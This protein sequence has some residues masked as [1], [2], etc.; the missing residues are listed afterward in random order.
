MR[1][2]VEIKARVS[3]MAGLKAR[4]K[5]VADQGPELIVQEDTFFHT[6]RGRLK[7][8]K[9]NDLQGELIYYERPD[10]AGPAQ[11][12]Y[13]ITP[14]SEPD[15]VIEMLSRSHGVKGVIRKKRTL[16][17]ADQTRIHLDEVEDLGAFVELEVVLRPDQDSAEG[18]EIAERL[19]DHLRIGQ[20]DLVETAYI[21]MLS[22]DTN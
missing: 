8:R 12:L 18:V 9:F 3:D 14:T 20:D 1:R 22:P 5:T 15:N 19:M 13:R 7:L 6:A 10:S 16:Y 2:N 4:V 11:C 21:D 17:L